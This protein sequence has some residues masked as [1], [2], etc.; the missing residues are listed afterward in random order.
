METYWLTSS[1]PLQEAE[2]FQDYR[3]AVARGEEIAA[4][5]KAEGFD[6]EVGLASQ[7]NMWAVRCTKEG[8]RPVILQVN[9]EQE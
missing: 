6:V 9:D 7:R 2:D 8:Y 5:L 3:E 1:D 4:E